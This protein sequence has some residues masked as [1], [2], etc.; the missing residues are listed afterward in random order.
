MNNLRSDSVP[1]LGIPFDAVSE[2]ETCQRMLDALQA[3]RGGQLVTANLDFLRR[4]RSDAEFAELVRQAELVVADGMPLVWASRLQGTPLPERVTGSSLSI[5]LA[6]HLAQ[7]P[8]TLFLLGG[9]PGVADQAAAMLQDRFPGLQIAGTD[10]PPWGFENDPC[11]LERIGDLLRATQPSV[12]YVALGSPK[13]ERLIARFRHELPGSWWIGVGISLSFITGE[14]SRAP[15]WVQRLG[16]EWLHRLWQEPRR[17]ARRY[18][19][20]GLPFALHLLVGRIL[21]RLRGGPT[22]W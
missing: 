12:I 15:V 22:R 3:G 21:V 20:D 11:E 17:L 1:L 19:L 18:L 16:L 9:N 4:C 7:T 13:Q 10:C 5:L 2:A 8:H 14:V 6:G